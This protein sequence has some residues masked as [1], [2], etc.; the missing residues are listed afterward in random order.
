MMTVEHL[1]FSYPCGRKI[2][3]DISFAA[4]AGECLAVLGNNG[5]GKSTL[6]KCFSHI[7]RPQSGRVLVDGRDILSLSLGELARE[8]ALMTQSAPSTRLTVYDTLLL[9][10]KPYMKWG[11]SQHDRAVVADILRQLELEPFA[12][13]YLDQLSG[14][15][16]QKILLA[17]A[18]VQEPKLL[19][20][21]EPTSSLDLKNQY[22]VLGLVRRFCRERNIT[23]VLVI[24]DLNL[25][26]RFCDR[27]LF[28]HGGR[29]LAFG[30]PEA[31]TPANIRAVYGMDA[32]VEQVRGVPVVIPAL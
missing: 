2:L 32:A 1:C 29:V 17:R 15:E 13:R 28:L 4:D 14:G 6:L 5:A 25:A 12:M 26:L 22:E 27:F 31:V 30:G 20:L 7:L 8:A 9:G 10:R 24:H 18:L 11:V 16:Q 23:A 19:L 21:D 3:E